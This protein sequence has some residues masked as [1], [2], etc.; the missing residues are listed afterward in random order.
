MLYNSANTKFHTNPTTNPTIGNK[1]QSVDD[2]PPIAAI[3][4]KDR[5][6]TQSPTIIPMKTFPKKEPIVMSYGALSNIATSGFFSDFV[7]VIGIWVSPIWGMFP[8]SAMIY[9]IIRD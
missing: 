8:I 5:A 2:S 4:Q 7:G 3:A 6:A 1:I 9:I